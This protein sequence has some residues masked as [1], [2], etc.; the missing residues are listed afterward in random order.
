M[1]SRE[2]FFPAPLWLHWVAFSD[3]VRVLNGKFDCHFPLVSGEWVGK[4]A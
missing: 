4:S 2:G 1:Q 3:W